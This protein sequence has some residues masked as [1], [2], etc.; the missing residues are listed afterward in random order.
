ML[1]EN[2]MTPDPV[3]LPP[4]ATISEA[5]IEMSRRKFRHILVATPLR[6]GKKLIGI[7]SK[8]D[9]ARAFP[10]D[11]NP[12]SLAVSESSVPNTI[13]TIMSSPAV[14]VLPRCHIENAARLLRTHHFNALPVVHENRLVGIITESDIFDALLN[15]TG[16][17]SVGVKL[18]V[19]SAMNSNPALHLAQ[20]S[21][22]HNL[23]IL[24]LASFV[25]R[26]SANIR[27]ILRF[28]GRPSS[29]F[30]EDLYKLGFRVLTID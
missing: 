10:N 17:S 29:R 7:V 24:A 23:E 27:S 26:S 8:Y 3:T 6:H 16:A 12:F 25:N 20:L 22:S 30:V 9:I 13:S 14:T 11:L 19:E 2:W 5:A 1:V 4:S 28:A 18:V 15:M 21:Q